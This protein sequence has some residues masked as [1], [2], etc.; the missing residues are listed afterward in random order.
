MSVET[1]LERPLG[2]TANEHVEGGAR[3]LGTLDEPSPRA[4]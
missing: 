4:R 2:G 1:V 3:A